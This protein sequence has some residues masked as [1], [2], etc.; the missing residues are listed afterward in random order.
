VRLGGLGKLKKIHC[1]GTRTHNLP[2]CSIVLQP[3][4]IPRA[5]VTRISN[6]SYL[7]SYFYSSFTDTIYSPD[8]VTQNSGDRKI[9]RTLKTVCPNKDNVPNISQK[10][11]YVSNNISKGYLLWIMYSTN[12]Y[13]QY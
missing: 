8:N 12:V 10:H 7:L 6:K 13:H 2:A 4:T 11:Y 9:I 1:I 3:T 5:P